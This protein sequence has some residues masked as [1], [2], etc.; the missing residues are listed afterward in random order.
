MD[1]SISSSLYSVILVLS[2]FI[3]IV[4]SQLMFVRAKNKDNINSS[5]SKEFVQI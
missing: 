3:T 4:L 1:V 2:L 5:Q